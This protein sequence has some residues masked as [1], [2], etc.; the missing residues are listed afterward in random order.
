MKPVKS[1]RLRDAFPP[2]PNPR[3]V[4]P[5]AGRADLADQAHARR[6]LRPKTI[7]ETAMSNSSVQVVDAGTVKFAVDMS[8]EHLAR[9]VLF[10]ARE[11]LGIDS[12]SAVA[13]LEAELSALLAGAFEPLVSDWLRK[14]AAQHPQGM[15]D[16]CPT[17]CVDGA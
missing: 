12:F 2:T 9:N 7:P 16:P 15:T 5:K 17:D 1:A 3:A 4:R 13:R 10:L 14:V 6:A 11:P 8:C